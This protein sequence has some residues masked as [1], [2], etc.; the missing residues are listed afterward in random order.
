[1][2]RNKLEEGNSI[3]EWSLEETKLEIKSTREA[4]Q[5]NLLARDINTRKNWTRKT[6]GQKDQPKRR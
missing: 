3:D 1:M 2:K 5:K 6:T 4:K